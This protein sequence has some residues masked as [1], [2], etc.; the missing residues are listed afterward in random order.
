AEQVAPSSVLARSSA[1][2]RHLVFKA[3]SSNADGALPPP[4]EEM[5]VQ[6]EVELSCC[7]SVGTDL[8][9]RDIEDFISEI[10]RLKK[11]VASLEAQLRDKQNSQHQDRLWSS[12]DP[13][14]S[15]LSLTLLCYT[16]AQDPPNSDGRSEDDEALKMKECFVRLEDCNHL[17]HT[18][19]NNTEEDEETEEEDGEYFIDEEDDEFVP[20]ENN[21]GSSDEDSCVKSEDEL[22]GKKFKDIKEKR[23]NGENKMEVQVELELSCCKSVG[24]DLSMRDIEDFISEICRLKKEVASLEAQLRDKQNSQHQ[25]RLWSSRDPRDSELSLTLLCYT[26][27]QDPPNSDGRSE[28]DEALKMKECFRKMRMMRTANL[29]HTR[30][31]DEDDEDCRN[32]IVN[33]VENKTKVDA[34]EDVEN[35]DVI[36]EDFVPAG[37]TYV[38]SPLENSE[39]SSDEELLLKSEENQKREN[40]SCDVCGKTFTYRRNFEK[41]DKTH[42][43]NKECSQLFL[44]IEMGFKDLDMPQRFF[45]I[46]CEMEV[47]VE[48]ELSCCKSV[49]TDLSMR[50]IEDF[51]SE[52]C[53]LKKEVAS[54]EA[55]LRDKQNSQH[56][57]RLWSSRD[58]RDSELSLTL[59]CYTDAQDPPNSDGRSEDDEALK[60]KE[61]FVRLEDCNHLIHT[62]AEDKDCRNLIQ[63]TKEHNEDLNEEEN[64]EEE[65]NGLK[66]EEYMPAENKSGSSG[67]DTPLKSEDEEIHKYFCSTCEKTLPSKRL[68]MKHERTHPGMKVFSCW[69]CGSGFLSFKERKLHVDEHSGQRAK[70]V[71]CEKCQKVLSSS[72]YLNIHMKIHSGEKPFHCTVCGKS[73]T[74]KG[75]L[76]GHMRMHTGERPFQCPHC[77]KDFT[78][79]SHLTKHV[80]RHTKERPYMC[81]QCGK[82]FT[83]AS[84]L[85]VHHAV[86]SEDKPHQCK[87]CRK[88]FKQ[89]SHLTSHERT[90]TGEKPYQCSHC[91]RRFD[92]SSHCSL[93]ERIHTGERPH[94]CTICGKSFSRLNIFQNHRRIHTGER[95]YKCSVCDKMFAR[96]DVLKTHMRVHTGEKPYHCSICGE[97][98]TYL[99]GFLAH[100]K[101]HNEQTA[102]ER[103]DSKL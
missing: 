6:V 13:R 4:L 98:F 53:R 97:N 2:F 103:T 62:R 5:E 25:D 16:D 18:R 78:H 69:I 54:L 50:D 28:D 61:C 39:G 94:H 38:S 80:R 20:A 75:N 92:S 87:Y 71:K 72:S 100:K 63:N 26:D 88:A 85:K 55:Q 65:G 57:D 64:N 82:T 27:A 30:A 89:L 96:G 93:H 34:H 35:E 48:L 86:H 1:I 19:A 32:L 37:L 67:E 31:E 22:K 73:F 60:M 43:E 36:D 101:K 40:I 52:I 59:L 45:L 17:I 56:Q 14:D 70:H 76:Q 77:Q 47:Q 99:G 90:H 3:P 24:T 9:M 51:I 29:I 23:R 74:M 44:T 58:P 81:S 10:C 66:N 79:S 49:G 15:E 33:T 7:K 21:N 12:R 8:S 91:E 102:Q 11:E 41:H 83:N 95:R 46:L 42:R 84:S 68:L